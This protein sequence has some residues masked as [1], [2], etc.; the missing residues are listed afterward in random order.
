MPETHVEDAG[1]HALGAG[2]ADVHKTCR[3][4]LTSS[5]LS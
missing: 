1:V 2:G 3:K 4:C 5:S